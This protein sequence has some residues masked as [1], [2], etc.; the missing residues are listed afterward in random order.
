MTV[1]HTQMTQ[2]TPLTP[3]A[4]NTLFGEGDV[5][6]LCGELFGRGYA[7]GLIDA[8][9]AAGMTIVGLSVGRRNDDGSL[10]A[11]TDDE[12][13]QAE[14]NLGG[15]IVNVP[16][17]AGFDMDAPEGGMTPTEMLKGMTLDNWQDY[18]LDWSAVEACR[19]VGT[20]RL[21]DAMA[22]A[23]GQVDKLVPAGSNV[24]FA[25]TMAGGIPRSKAFLAIANRVYKGRGARYQSSQSLIDSDLGK[26]ILQNFEDVTA[27]SFGHLLEQSS[28]LRDR[29]ETAGG[30]VRYTAYGYHGTRI[31]IDGAYHWQTYTNYTQGYAKMHLERLAQQAWE[32]GV[33]ATVY[34]CPEIRT[35]SSDVF[36]GIELSLLPLLEALRK[37]GGG[38]HV[39]AL[40]S[41]CQALLKEDVTLDAVL[42]TVRAYQLDPAIRSRGDFTGW[43]M[44]NTPEQVDLS[45]GTSQDIAGL[46][47]DRQALISDLLSHHVVASTG[48]L[49]FDSS[50]NPDGPVLWLDHDLVARQIIGAGG[51]SAS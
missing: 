3:P 27:N 44:P 10:R 13:A 30:Q 12:L 31:L 46:H 9:K 7:T 40:W 17:M 11:L 28:G 42:E 32:K 25:H 36:A 50:S 35:N 1:Q 39:E 41:Q 15:Q 6:V 5:F 38:D 49:M 51:K 37:E 18:K 45:V 2:P 22:Q 21:A 29:I 26:L 48:Q 43:P 8:A 24:L 23:M 33:K 20:A 34:N 16:L 14:A 47:K 4:E 19:E